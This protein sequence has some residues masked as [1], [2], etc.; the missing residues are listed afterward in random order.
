[1]DATE[2]LSQVQVAYKGMV[3]GRTE[4]GKRDPVGLVPHVEVSRK[5]FLKVAEPS[6]YLSNGRFFL[7]MEKPISEK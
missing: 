7:T 3:S 4:I 1:M 5:P 6:Q 2:R